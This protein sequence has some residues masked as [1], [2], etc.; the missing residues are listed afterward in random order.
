MG[1]DPRILGSRPELKADAQPLNHPGFL[2]N[3]LIAE[4]IMQELLSYRGSL[5]TGVRLTMNPKSELSILCCLLLFF[6]VS[7]W[8]DGQRERRKD[9]G[10]GKNGN[11][12]TATLHISPGHHKN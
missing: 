10:Q 7:R 1:L 6:S 12:R 9:W 3:V 11:P 2:S 4:P 8:R 5:C